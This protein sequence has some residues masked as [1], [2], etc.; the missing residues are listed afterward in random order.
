MDRKLIQRAVYE[1]LDGKYTRNDTLRMLS[2]YSHLSSEYIKEM[3]EQCGKSAVF[4]IVEAIVDGIKEELN[5]EKLRFP[6]IWYREKIDSSS[7]KLRK[8]GIQNIKQ[9]LYDYIAV[10][11]IK[12]FTKYIGEYQCAAIKGRGQSYGIRAIRRWM[13]NRSIRY[14]GKADI[15]KCYPN[16]PK[17]KLMEF[18]HRHIKNDKLL[19]LIRTLVNTF[20]EGLSI[21]SYLSQF[22][23]NLYLAQLYHEISEN[24]YKIRKKKNGE[25]ERINLVK[26]V[27]FYM[28]DL[29]ILG[30]NAKDVHKAIDL[31]IKKAKVMGLEIKSDWIVFKTVEKRK[32]DGSFIDM[33]GVRIYRNHI[34]IRQRVFLRVR[35]AYKKAKKYR[36]TFRKIPIL[37]ARKCI[38]YYGIIK[39]TNSYQLQKKYDIKKTITEC[40]EVIR[41]ESKIFA[42]TVAG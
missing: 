30:T 38:A 40:K 39:N 37:L 31:V 10:E 14:A 9:Q 13:R 33:M 7:Q 23:C 28:D 24:M 26:H 35:R 16:I 17:D 25:K 5:Q 19:W 27:L 20:D 2:E 41:N 42:T 34:T 36:N 15:K 3:I 29:L 18:L 21:G 6:S 1:C 4:P 32:D 12:P 22:L 11:G 8:I